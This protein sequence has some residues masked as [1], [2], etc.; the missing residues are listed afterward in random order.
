ML[1]LA[2]HGALGE[3]RE[4]ELSSLS[5]KG[6]S[7]SSTMLVETIAEYVAQASVGL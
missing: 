4:S 1:R 5:Q 3:G 2:V 7:V 6:A